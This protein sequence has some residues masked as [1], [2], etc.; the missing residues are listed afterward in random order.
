VNPT[1]RRGA[2]DHRESDQPI[3][4]RDGRTDHA[5]KG[6]TGIR[7]SVKETL[8]DEEGSEPTMQTSL[9]AIAR[10]AQDL[11]GIGFSICMG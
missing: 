9:L 1:K 7:K 2:D 4:L 6:L 5:G 8:S 10:K 11:K 3:V